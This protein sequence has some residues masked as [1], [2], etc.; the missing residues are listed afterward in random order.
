MPVHSVQVV[1]VTFEYPSNHLIKSL[2][3]RFAGQIRFGEALK[4]NDIIDEETDQYTSAELIEQHFGVT[5]CPAFIAQLTDVERIL[6]RGESILVVPRTMHVA[7]V[8]WLKCYT[9]MVCVTVIFA[10]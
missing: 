8:A 6:Y 4:H 5:E 9:Q 2:S 10:W 3:Q 7:S 1:M